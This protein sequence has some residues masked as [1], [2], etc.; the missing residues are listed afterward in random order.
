MRRILMS[1]TRLVLVALPVLASAQ[2]SAQCA[3]DPV[4]SNGTV[5]CSGSDPDGIDVSAYSNVLVDILPGANVGTVRIRSGS[6]VVGQ[7]G[8]PATLSKIVVAVDSQSDPVFPVTAFNYGAITNGTE[9]PFA[10]ME[11]LLVYNYGQVGGRLSGK[12]VNFE[13]A[14]VARLEGPMLNAGSVST[15]VFLSDQV[16]FQI[17]NA[18]GGMVN[19]D[20]PMALSPFEFAVEKFEPENYRF[21]NF[22][23]VAGHAGVSAA[24]GVVDPSIRAGIFSIDAEIVNRATGRILG[25][26]LVTEQRT[27]LARNQGARNFGRIDGGVV[28][29]GQHGDDPR[30]RG[31]PPGILGRFVN[32]DGGRVGGRIIASSGRF[33]QRAGSAFD[34]GTTLHP[35]AIERR[36]GAGR[37]IPALEIAPG[38]VSIAGNHTVDCVTGDPVVVFQT[39][40]RLG[41]LELLAGATLTVSPSTQCSYEG[42]ITGLGTLRKTGSAAYIYS[43]TATHGSTVVQQGLWF[44]NGTQ[45]PMTIENSG[46]VIGIGRMGD[47]LVRN[48]GRLA[49]GGTPG[50]LAAGSLTMQS[51]S[52]F[53][54]EANATGSDLLDVA[55][56]VS[57][58]GAT[59]D[60]RLLAGYIH[61]PG[62]AMT[63]IANDGADPVVGTFGGRAEGAEF[64]LGGF[65]FRIR[66]A[67]GTGNDVLLFAL[68]PAAAITLAP[69][70]GTPNEGAP[71]TLTATVT[72]TTPT[73]V[74]TFRDGTTPIAGCVDQP[75]MP[76]G[77]S[78]T[79][80][81]TT[82]ALAAGARSLSAVYGGDNTNPSRTSVAVTATING[83]PN[84]S[85]PTS[86]SVLEDSV[87]APLAI[88][89]GDPES[90]ATAVVLWAT[91][92][93][94]ALVSDTALAAGFSGSGA[95]R[96]L[97]V[98]PNADAFGS[99]TITL[100][101]SDPAGA[102]RTAPLALTVTPVNDPPAFT[103]GGNPAHP[104]GTTGAQSRPGFVLQLSPGPLEAAQA[105]TL[106]ISEL[107]DAGNLVTDA[108]LATD[109]T[110]SYTLSGASGV[111]RLQVVAQ[112]NGGTTD[113]GRD[114]TQR[115]F[116]I[117]VGNGADLQA[118]LK[119]VAPDPVTGRRAY[120]ITARNNGPANL[121]GVSVRGVVAAGLSD[122]SWTCTGACAAASGT[123][124]P[125]LVGDFPAGAV[126]T[127]VLQGAVD[128]AAPFV[129]L[130]ATI[131][132][133]AGVVVLNPADDRATLVEAAGS[134]GLLRDGFEP[135]LQRPE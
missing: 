16:D 102:A 40:P 60:P 69:V 100:A 105:V 92:G 106:S 27:S 43:G 78:A 31:E 98:A 112:D 81:C 132:P 38:T 72:G 41:Q 57:L 61:Q 25:A 52:V 113:G 110:L 104:T 88:T 82:S 65:P 6:V 42:Q 53:E 109:G 47:T 90:G 37:G 51:P 9:V 8:S 123:G 22:G 94:A 48:G 86:L 66:Y 93:D 39:R 84:L 17:T 117:V 97:T 73:G 75:L 10:P 58:G 4:A 13:D 20:V 74:V 63:M 118:G 124:A 44:A 103:L 21:E 115:E 134:D 85:A 33:E 114:R 59:L 91:S 95:N 76:N 71:V 28:L 50:T 122:L 135:V 126:A 129:S 64:T 49:P 7:R 111:A 108:A 79:A 5:T 23:M 24:P 45:G 34:P 14:T 99:T 83:Q 130:E 12:L 56:T 116:R 1:T 32:E 2:V 87:G 46:I 128:A 19:G 120:R 68:D 29:I 119:R 62:R 36:R 89:V 125:L 133:P 77:D 3:P 101:A 131:A 80:S 30:P 127:I 70:A 15:A 67:A 54:F 18:A 26:L 121:A 55:G 96:T 35:S 107:E 11:R